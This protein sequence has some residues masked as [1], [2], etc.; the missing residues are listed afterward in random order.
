MKIQQNQ[1]NYEK[2]IILPNFQLNFSV[3]CAKVSTVFFYKFYNNLIS[4][5]VQWSM[6]QN[7]FG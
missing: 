1:K 5:R 6:E 7:E 4:L 3:Y 2:N